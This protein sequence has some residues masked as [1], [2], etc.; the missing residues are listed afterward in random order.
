VTYSYD[1]NGNL[2]SAGSQKY[3]WDYRNR[4]A[5]EPSVSWFTLWHVAD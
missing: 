1:N 4:I 5:N 2:T 3:T